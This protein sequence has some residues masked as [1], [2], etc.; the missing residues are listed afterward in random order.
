MCVKKQFSTV[1]CTKSKSN[2]ENAFAALSYIYFFF[3]FSM[4]YCPKPISLSFKRIVPP[5]F[6]SSAVFHAPSCPAKA[7][8]RRLSACTVSSL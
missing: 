4:A 1:K 7:A 6:S 8:S 2:K 5:L 3:R